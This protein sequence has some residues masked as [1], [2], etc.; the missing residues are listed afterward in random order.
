MATREEL[1]A[2][3][4][5]LKGLAGGDLFDKIKALN[6]EQLK[7]ISNL[8]DGEQRLA[9]LAK[10]Q[11]SNLQRTVE[12]W[13]TRKDQLD[14]EITRL[15]EGAREDESRYATMERQK[16]IKEAQA[17]MD[18]VE[19]KSLE[20]KLRL[21]GKLEKD[22]FK[23]LEHLRAI[24]EERE[25]EKKH[26]QDA[27]EL[28]T[29][30]GKIFDSYGK[31]SFFNVDTLAKF[32]SAFKQPGQFFKTLATSAVKN[33]VNSFINVIFEMDKAESAFRKATGA[34]DD[35]ASSMRASH[36]ETRKFGV[37]M[38]ELGE[39]MK[40]LHKTYTDFTMLD[41]DQRE[42]LSETGA[43]L[44][45]L[46][47][48]NQDF[49]QIMQSSTKMFGQGA[50]EAGK[51]AIELEALGR[52]IGVAPETM[53]A[54]F[55]K[56]ASSLAKL[57]RDG[58]AA[59]KKLAIAAKVTGFEVDKIIK[60]TERFDTFEGAADQAGKLNAALG[61]NFVNAMDLMT[62]TDPVERFEMIRDAISS[63]GLTF[64]D[65]SYYQR[66]FYTESLGLSDVGELAQVMSG[67]FD[68][69]AGDV[70]KTSKEYEDMRERAAQVQNVTEQFKGIMMDLVVIF[71]PAI[72][73]LQSFV[74]GLRENEGALKGLVTIMG[75][76]LGLFVLYKLGMMALTF[77]GA[78]RTAG[79]IGQT[80]AQA[81]NNGVMGMANKMSIRGLKAMKRIVPV[82][83]AFGAAG[84]MIGVGIGIAALGLAQMVLAFQGLGDAA[85]PATV[86]IIG[87]TV[88]FGAMMIGLMF[89]VAG[90][91]AALAAG[92]VGVLLAVGQAA[93]MI[94]GGMALAAFGMSYFLDTLNPAKLVSLAAASDSMIELA[95]G[96]GALGLAFM[97]LGTPVAVAGIT[98]FTL[99]VMG[100][101]TAFSLLAWAIKPL[102][103]PLV[104]MTANLAAVAEGNLD[105][106]AKGFERITMAIKGIPLTKTIALK[107]TMDSAIGVAQARS[108]TMAM[109]SASEAAA[110][111]S[112]M[113]GAPPTAA[114]PTAAAAAAP[115]RPYN[116][117]IRLELEGEKLTE[118]V[119][120]IVGGAAKEATY[121]TA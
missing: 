101:S 83:L 69:L 64:D 61:G 25:K 102:M 45:E 48:K 13:N 34:S 6:E 99:G 43:L 2:L 31:H 44:A 16:L 121:G 91:Q 50:I 62:A 46:G 76:V 66:K 115:E 59:F 42:G 63:T 24:N 100:L 39:T 68:D 93:L 29:D 40:S 60:L 38:K 106:V 89:L 23:R 1:E 55:A 112:V 30:M 37:D 18:K 84:L 118:K 65:M 35:F 117:T 97:I 107:A 75:I 26:L 12:Y 20:E 88:A 92:A 41:K 82:M 32:G 114:A 119:V 104:A 10:Q 81:A 96:L 33:F 7:Y 108:L 105:E 8:G 19:L 72:D 57:G 77:V 109:T 56:S 4:G 70:G 3:L 73:G 54:G 51:T 22:E 14:E 86:A 15:K 103:E 85:W 17:E 78:L 79:I 120:R 9:D 27:K 21:T 116:V 47:V 49:A 52:D 90:P 98:A 71:G 87:F 111:R 113:F 110:T 95:K 28:A 5:E 67:N 11:M 53:A 58:P 36:A 94:G 74:R 80:K